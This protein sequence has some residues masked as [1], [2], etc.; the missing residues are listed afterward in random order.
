VQDSGR[1]G[2]IGD[3]YGYG[4]VLARVKIRVKQSNGEA[5]MAFQLRVAKIPHETEYRFHPSRKWRADFAIP[6]RKLLIEV[7]GGS[8]TEG[9]HNRGKGFEDDCEKYSVA[10]ALGWR[11]IR[12]TTGQV[13]SG[14]AL[15]WIKAAM[16][17]NQVDNEAP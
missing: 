9:R 14:L 8:W 13:E 16:V 11:V 10:A 15:H 5:L 12:A 6:A 17:V 7:E 2:V 1:N 3:V 4:R